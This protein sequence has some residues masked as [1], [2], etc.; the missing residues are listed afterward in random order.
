MLTV[1]VAA[2][3]ASTAAAKR[4]Q[5]GGGGGGGSSPTGYD[6]SYPQCGGPLPSNILFGIVGVND[7]I[8][9]SANPCLGAGSSASELQ[10]AGQNAILYA[11]TG[12]PGPSLSHHWPNGQ[13]SPKQCN[14]T[15]SPGSDTANCA[16]DYGWNAAADSYQ[17][18]VN[19]YVSLGWAPTGSTRTPVANQW[20]LDV[21]IAN[22][23][24]SNLA[25]NVADLQ[26]AVDY[27]VSVGA[28]GVGFY[29]SPSDW[30]TITGSTAT[31]SARGS[32]VAGAG[33]QTTAQ[34]KCGTT[35]FTGGP[36]LYS[37]YA[38]SGFDADVRC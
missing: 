28:S 19:A 16:Y 5:H 20:W 32:W 9:Y 36:V 29:S 13:T 24:E 8:V 31:F 17:D 4:P 27:L 14:T 35:G 22:S 7:G 12:N 6:V 10:W 38:S 25:N 26:G 30:A 15:S 34:S 23:W 33:S 3:F 2:A 37:Q 11:N 18:G 1:F 21:E